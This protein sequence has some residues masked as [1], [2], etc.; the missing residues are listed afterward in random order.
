MKKTGF[1]EK[2]IRGAIALVLITALLAGCGKSGDTGVCK[3]NWILL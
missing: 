1:M 3:P 2:T